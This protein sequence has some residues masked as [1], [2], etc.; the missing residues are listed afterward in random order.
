MASGWR[1]YLVL[2][3][4]ALPTDVWQTVGG[5]CGPVLKLQLLFPEVVYI[6][7]LSLSHRPVV[8]AV[9]FSVSC[10]FTD[11]RTVGSI[12][13]CYWPTW[14]LLA[15]VPAPLAGFNLFIWTFSRFFHLNYNYF[16]DISDSGKCKLEILWCLFIAFYLGGISFIFAS[17][18][19]SSEEPMAVLASTSFEETE[20]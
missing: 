18:I 17:P 2:L 16:N 11:C 14:R 12:T 1:I 4:V 8:E 3:A 19:S 10:F 9:L 6:F 15:A 13:C 20:F 5:I 7:M